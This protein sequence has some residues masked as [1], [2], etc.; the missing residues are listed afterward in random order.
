MRLPGRGAR[1]PR[2]GLMMR[3]VNKMASRR[4][5]RTGKMTGLGFNALILATVGVKSGAERSTP[6]G[7][8]P[9]PDGS[10]LIV[11]S[12]AGAVRNPARYHNIARIPAR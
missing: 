6:V 7:W 3:W 12:A 1:P 5:L 2:A 11:A 4:I 9:D 10:W 8:F